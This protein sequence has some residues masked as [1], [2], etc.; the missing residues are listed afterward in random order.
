MYPNVHCST[1]DRG[2]HKE[3][4]VHMHNGILMK[5]DSERQTSYDIT[6]VWNYKNQTN[7]KDTNEFIC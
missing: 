7:K 4:E 6:Y 5:L 3:D 1:I 2:M